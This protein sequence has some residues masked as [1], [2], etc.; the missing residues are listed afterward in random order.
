MSKENCELSTPMQAHAA[1]KGMFIMIKG[2]PCKVMNVKTSKTGKHG[3]VKVRLTGLC[4][5]T[6]TKYE[7]VR[8]GHIVMQAANVE[9]TDVQLSFVEDSKDGKK[10]VLG[11]L[12]ENGDEVNLDVVDSK[13][14][15][16]LI[17]AKL[18]DTED[19]FD[20]EVT[21]VSAPVAVGAGGSDDEGK[22][23]LQQVHAITQ[24]K[25]HVPP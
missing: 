19:A 10:K 13:E 2:R 21:I 9:K 23:R 20:F 18:A 14:R 12:D 15:Q 5:I 8:A 4:V 24:W 25:A 11:F 16:E 17:A 3:H 1:K 6:K 7:V 22:M